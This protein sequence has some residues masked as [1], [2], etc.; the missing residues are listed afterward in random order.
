[1]YFR[2]FGTTLIPLKCGTRYFE[3]SPLP[4]IKNI[5]LWDV[6]KTD[7]RID[8]MVIREPFDYFE[9]A[10]HT[11]VIRIMNLGLSDWELNNKIKE[12]L[13]SYNSTYLDG[14]HYST[15][16]H[17]ILYKFWYN[18]KVDIELV[19]IKNLSEWLYSKTGVEQTY[20]RPDYWFTNERIWFDRDWIC[21]WISS[22]FTKEWESI[23]NAIQNEYV[24][25]EKLVN[26]ERIHTILI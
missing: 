4:F 15:N 24:W 12:M 14:H 2:V 19:D 7:V 21:K 3:S 23:I 26:R 13:K 17:K 8:S 25:Y 9:S 16:V 22:N 11:D 18:N 5:E 10:L 1:M 20:Y 6:M